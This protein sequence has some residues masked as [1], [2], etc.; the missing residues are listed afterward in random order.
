MTDPDLLRLERR[1]LAVGAVALVVA[2]VGGA[3]SPAAFFRAWLVSWLFWLSIP[4]GALA[5]V[6][7]H[8][9][10]GGSWG[11]VIRRISESTAATLPL[12]ALLFV[13]IALGMRAIYEWAHPDAAVPYQ[14]AYLNVPFFL[15]RAVLYFIAWIA[16]ARVLVRWSE[17]RDLIADPDPRRFRL[18]AGPG[19]VIYGFT[20]T[21]ASIDWAMSI[22]PHWSSTVY[23]LMFGV[24]QVL[25]GFAFTITMAV[26]LRDR[27]PFGRL[28]NASNLVDLG[29]LMLTFVLLWAYLSFSQLLLIYAGNVRE[30]V[31]WYLARERPGWLAVAFALIGVHFFLPFALLLQ[32]TVKRNPVALG[33]VAVLILVMR[34][35]DDYWLVLP[36]IRGAEGFH[37]LYV[38]TP[39]AVGGLWLAA[40]T[41]RLRGIAL[42]PANEPLVEQAMA[43]HGH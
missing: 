10:A 36:G 37:W 4:L 42:V 43:A 23:P 1:A 33:A 25:A 18:F 5:I 8:Y 16:V 15:A 7:L 38:V 29:N 17:Q 27:E 14:H 20:V 13:P 2:A 19:L 41:R 6:M 11:I 30:E 21:F 32:R 9:L 22:E 35:V 39:L 3:F 26:A 31:T 34:L 40:F 24:G 28:V 12:L